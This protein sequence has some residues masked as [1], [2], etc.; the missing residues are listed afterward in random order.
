MIYI[1]STIRNRISEFNDTTHLKTSQIYRALDYSF[2][3]LKVDVGY[4]EELVQ[5]Y[6]S[7]TYLGRIKFLAKLMKFKER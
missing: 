6:D 3:N 7:L 2:T 4:E 1:N 5:H